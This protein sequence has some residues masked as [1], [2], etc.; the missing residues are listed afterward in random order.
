MF[1]AQ[2]G[3]LAI[4]EIFTQDA[5][6]FILKIKKYNHKKNITTSGIIC[7]TPENKSHQDSRTQDS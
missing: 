1:F 3:R 7:L 5:I 4:H 2:N 6:Y